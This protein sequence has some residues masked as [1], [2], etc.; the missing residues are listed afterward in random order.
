MSNSITYY[1]RTVATDVTASLLQVTAQCVPSREMVY[2]DGEE[3]E[4]PECQRSAQVH[5]LSRCPTLA[6]AHSTPGCKGE[7]TTHTHMQCRKCEESICASRLLSVTRQ[8]RWCLVDKYLLDETEVINELSL[9]LSQLI[10]H[11]QNHHSSL[12]TEHINT[13][14]QANSKHTFRAWREIH[15]WKAFTADCSIKEVEPLPAHILFHK[16][17]VNQLH[18]NKE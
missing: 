3:W 12:T 14:A 2:P 15:H 9:P 1:S 10:N 11:L 18:R 13:S 4:S 8:L 5:S 7:E 6:W 17:C 16:L